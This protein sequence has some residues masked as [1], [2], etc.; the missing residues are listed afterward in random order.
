[1]NIATQL[2]PRIQEHPNTTWDKSAF[3]LSMNISKYSLS[4]G[5]RHVCPQVYNSTYVSDTHYQ[6]TIDTVPCSYVP[7]LKDVITVLISSNNHDDININFIINQISALYDINFEV[8]TNLTVNTSSSVRV[9]IYDSKLKEG[10]QLNGIIKDIKTP[11]IFLVKNLVDFNNQ[12]SIERMIRVIDDLK[13]LGVAVSSGSIR[14]ATGHW[15][16]GCLQSKALNYILSYRMGYYFSKH[17]CSYC[18]DILSPFV[19]S[20]NTFD[21][22]KFSDYLS[23]QVMIRDWFLKL[24]DNGT[25][26]MICPDVM[27][28]VKDFLNEKYEDWKEFAGIWKFNEIRMELI[29]NSKMEF[30]CE[31][32]GISCSNYRSILELGQLLPKCCTKIFQKNVKDLIKY[33][34]E[35]HLRYE[36]NAGNVLGA[37]KLKGHIPWDIDTDIAILCKDWS[38]WVL[39]KDS[40][41]KS[42]GCSFKLVQN[43][44][45]FTVYCN[46]FFI[47]F[48]CI[49]D[50]S[51]WY[52]PNSVQNFSTKLLYDG[53]WMYTR[54][55]PGLYSR[56]LYKF[57][58]LRHARHWRYYKSDDETK[59]M[60]R[61]YVP[62]VS[63]PPCKSNLQHTCQNSFPIDGNIPILT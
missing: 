58:D 62:P 60:D 51:T 18:D 63:W 13:Y 30:S 41:L 38:K 40:Y 35:N 28:Y 54:G 10:V 12:S 47:E 34:D 23:G 50:L 24:K 25:L 2:D 56:N 21:K 33:A 46:S 36:L 37:I 53:T 55:N 15:I 31:D 45:Y 26:S 61:Y 44:R 52:L 1:M 43:N 6:H 3:L 5:T 49:D 19:V 4:N 9:N 8:L 29:Q 14:N 48:Y 59:Q 39:I 16:L 27:F 32:I 57:D 11:Y 17:E 22:V 7:P 20:K 42:L